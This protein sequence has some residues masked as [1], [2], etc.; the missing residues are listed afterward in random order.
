MRGRGVTASTTA[1]QVDEAIILFELRPH[2]D[3]IALIINAYL[4]VHSSCLC[5]L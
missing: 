5:R 3:T 1:G 2:S 4:M